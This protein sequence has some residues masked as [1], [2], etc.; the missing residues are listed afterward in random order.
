MS[1]IVKLNRSDID[2][3]QHFENYFELLRSSERAQLRASIATEKGK[4]SQP[5]LSDVEQRIAYLKGAVRMGRLLCLISSEDAKMKH[6]ILMR[7]RDDLREQCAR[8]FD[9]CGV[10]GTVNQVG[11]Y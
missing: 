4:N 1:D 8:R 3:P 2:L 10:G 11:P 9:S 6:Q 7:E 5:L